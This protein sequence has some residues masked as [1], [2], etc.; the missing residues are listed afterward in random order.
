VL[1]GLILGIGAGVG[2]TALREFTDDAVH[3][4][5]ELEAETKLPVLVGIP[6][7]V[8]PEDIVQN[9]RRRWAWVG[10]ATVSVALTVAVLHFTV[11]ELDVFWGMIAQ[12]LPL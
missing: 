5:D 10:A 3:N 1:L 9:S 4:P 11:I 2:L 8:T 7:I 6:V 12:I